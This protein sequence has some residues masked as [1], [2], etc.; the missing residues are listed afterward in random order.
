MPY[1]RTSDAEA[2]AVWWNPVQTLSKA[3]VPTVSFSEERVVLETSWL[4]TRREY[5]VE[6]FFAG[7][8]APVDR[9]RMYLIKYILVFRNN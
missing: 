4:A 1:K 5:V 7:V 2:G 8:L 3:H 9:I 6:M